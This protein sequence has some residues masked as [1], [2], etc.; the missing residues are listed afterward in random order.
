MPG[1]PGVL[2]VITTRARGVADTLTAGVG[3]FYTNTGDALGGIRRYTE[4]DSESAG[5]IN[6]TRGRAGR[7]PSAEPAS[8]Y[9]PP[10][11][12]IALRSVELE[13]PENSTLY[14]R[15]PVGVLGK[16]HPFYELKSAVGKFIYKPN[17]GERNMRIGIPTEPGS[18][19][20]REVAAFRLDQLLGFDRIP[21]TALTDGPYGRGSIQEWV[22]STVSVGILSYSPTQRQQMAVLDYIMANSDRVWQNFRTGPAGDVIAID[23]SLT[24]PEA[25]DPRGGIRSDFVAAYRREPLDDDILRA[26]DAVDPKELRA[27]LEDLRLSEPAISGAL[28]R[29][30]EIRENRMIM[31]AEWPDIRRHS[32]SG[33]LLESEIT[34]S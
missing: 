21:P 12:E 1:I 32:R 19:A 13:H 22:K 2:D 28:N 10:A 26:V 30:A 29:L 18:Q 4:V 3:R 20:A 16:P 31:G 17:R 27:A 9:R 15:R 7:S 34:G 8:R 33:P 24:F 25:P 14:R 11:A 23:H 5:Q 6:L